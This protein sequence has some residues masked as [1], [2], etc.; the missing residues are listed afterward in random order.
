MENE[1]KLDQ[2]NQSVLEL[3]EVPHFDLNLY[4]LEL[5][6]QGQGNIILDPV[7]PPC[8]RGVVGSKCYRISTFLY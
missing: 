6:P 7:L 5:E 8:F 4:T 3:I 2:S 1:G